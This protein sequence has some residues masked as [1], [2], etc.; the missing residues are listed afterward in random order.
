MQLPLL[1][2]FLRHFQCRNRPMAWVPDSRREETSMPLLAQSLV[3]VQPDRSAQFERLTDNATVE[4]SNAAAGRG[5]GD[6]GAG[7]V[8][9]PDERCRNAKIDRRVA[10][11]PNAIEIPSDALIDYPAAAQIRCRAARVQVQP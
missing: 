7:R 6:D 3:E 2:H 10:R 5:D 4:F 1:L 8:D 9:A 11:Q